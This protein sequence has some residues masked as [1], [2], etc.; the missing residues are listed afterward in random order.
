[1]KEFLKNRLTGVYTESLSIK[2]AFIDIAAHFANMPGTVL[3]MSGGDLDS[4]RYNILCVK[5]WLTYKGKGSEQTI[6]TG[7]G[8][9]KFN[10]DPFS[11]LKKLVNAF[12]LSGFNLSGF[13]LYGPVAAGLFGYLAYDLKDFIEDLPKTSVDDLLLP[14]ICFFAPSIILI[15]DKMKNQTRLHIPEFEDSAGNNSKDTVEWFFSIINS[16]LKASEGFKG[17]LKG[18]ESNFKKTDYID[19]IQRIKEY[20][21]Q[22]HVY[23]VNM[24]QR[25]IMDFSGDTF[26]LF[27]EL[28]KNN[29]ASFFAYINAGDHRIISTS[30]ERFI[31]RRGNSIETRPIKG[32]RPR[33]KDLKQDKKMK[34]ELEQSIKDD[35]ELS[36]IVDLLRN[37]LGK[38]C[39]AGSVKVTKHKMLEAYSN[40]YHLVSV[41]EGT[42]DPEVDSVDII[43]AAFPGGSITGCPK[44]RAME[45]I[46]ELEPNR[47][48]IYTGSIG[49]ISFHDTMDLSIA[50]RTATVL[51]G[52]IIFSVGGGLVFDSNPEDE[53]EETLHK[54]KTLMEV[55]QGKGK[56]DE[57]DSYIWL[58]GKMEKSYNAGVSVSDP[59]FQYGAGFFET[60][61]V[62]K[63]K[64]QYLKEHMTRFN[65]AWEYLFGK[66]APDLTWKDIISSVIV[67]NSL[68]NKISAVKIIATSGDRNEAPFNNA[69]IVMARPYIHRLSGKKEQG[70][71]LAVYPDPR[72]TPLAD[73]KT[74]NYFYYYRAGKWAASK[75]AD[76]ALILNPDGT[77][78]ETNT[79]NI[80]ILRDKTVLLP[81]SQH[82]LNG[83]MQDKVCAF[84]ESNGFKI[85]K[86]R[87]IHKDLFKGSQLIITNSLMGAVPVLSINGQKTGMSSNF[88]QKI[89]KKVL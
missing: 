12:N 63:G 44:V 8:V 72:Q 33:G 64:S 74:L 1:M 68:E 39:R 14:D 78:S 75:G 23:Q 50:I 2:D 6:T 48:H 25:F 37:D 29:P 47:R 45:I 20:I 53:F 56:K 80:L 4:S 88:W 77:V 10:D 52:K 83:V 30:P 67:K 24:A 41:V 28:F 13:D 16:G 81:Y 54:G 86:K 51:N 82:M 5:P 26:S 57:A 43:K 7:K 65:L 9:Y 15:H 71:N 32:T 84:L 59:G 62:N 19:S 31:L 73:Y 60:I 69:L 58:N 27:Q 18:F 66:K 17:N 61:R 79:G 87:M 46:D 42:L 70:L 36:M 55:F 38:V 34:K 3:L 11:I 85:E 49:Y 21:T 40:V 35:A 89:N 76:E 22:G